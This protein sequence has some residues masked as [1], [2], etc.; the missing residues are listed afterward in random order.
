MSENDKHAAQGET[1]DFA[2]RI[3]A[4][5]ARRVAM[6]RAAAPTGTPEAAS[7][8]AEAVFA[9]PPPITHEELAEILALLPPDLRNGPPGAFGMCS[10]YE[11]QTAAQIALALLRRARA[12]EA[13]IEGRT[14]P[15][16]DAEI[17]A[18]AAQRCPGLWLTRDD[19]GNVFV[20]C[21]GAAVARTRENQA[22]AGDDGTRW[23][24][25]DA[26]GRPCAWPV[27]QGNEVEVLT[28]RMESAR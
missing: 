28:R 15:P 18:H 23:I 2:D 25:L 13:I 12:A 21:G 8:S 9:K 14:K 6:R 10:E 16:T 5:G 24:S 19:G 17:A 20:E 1:S 3:Q 11:R 7:R 27:P 22:S 26:A 4:A